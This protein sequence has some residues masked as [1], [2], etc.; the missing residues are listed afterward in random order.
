M[1]PPCYAVDKIKRSIFIFKCTAYNIV[2]GIWVSLVD[3]SELPNQV[4][5]HSIPA[6]F[7]L[8][9]HNRYASLTSKTRNP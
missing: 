4:L 2:Y 6:A 3:E 1:M 5:T 7:I 9:K 8:S